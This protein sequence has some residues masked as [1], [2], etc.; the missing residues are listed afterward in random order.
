MPGLLVLS[1]FAFLNVIDGISA[2]GRRMVSLFYRRLVC[3][4]SIAGARLHVSAWRCVSA[5]AFGAFPHDVLY[6]GY[7]LYIVDMAEE[8]NG[9]T[10]VK[11]ML[12]DDL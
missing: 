1:S 4:S 7:Q 6:A 12:H 10:S 2:E 11:R 5:S 8:R 3:M 9:L